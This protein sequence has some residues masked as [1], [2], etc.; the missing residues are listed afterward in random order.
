MTEQKDNENWERET[1]NKLAFAA[2]TEQRR[3]RRWTM[4]FRGL[5]L[6]WMFSFLA[7]VIVGEQEAN[8]ELGAHTALIEVKGVISDDAEASADNIVTA[9]RK[10]FKNKKCRRRDPAYQ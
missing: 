4:V 5:V 10:A 7:L 2:I 9:L 8:L 1:I 6:I 3:A